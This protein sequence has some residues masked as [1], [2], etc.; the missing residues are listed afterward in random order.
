MKFSWF[1]YW[2][3]TP[4]EIRK[5]ADSILASATL[6]STYSVFNEQKEFALIVMIVSAVAKFLSNFYTDD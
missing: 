2:K 5:V 3:P 6:I 4:I 1:G